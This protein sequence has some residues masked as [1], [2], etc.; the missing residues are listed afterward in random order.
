MEKYIISP[1]ATIMEALRVIN[2][3]IIAV[4]IVCENGIVRGVLTDGDL[5]RAL[6]GGGGLDSLIEPFYSQRYFS[7]DEDASRAD[8]LDLMQAHNLQHIPIV[9]AHGK[10]RGI[11]T[12]HS[13]L[14]SRHK[15]NVAVIMAGGL[16]SRLGKLTSHTPKPMLKVAGKPILER[17]VLHL[18]GHGI[19][20]IYLSVNYLSEVIEDYFGDGSKWGCSI[21][22]LREEQPLGSGGS[23]SL[24]PPQ[25]KP[26]FLLNG[27][28]LL[29]GNLSE[30]L[31]FHER[32]SFY[33]T[34]GT[35][36]YSHEVPYGC[37]ETNEG[38]IVSLEEKPVIAKTVNAGVYVLSPEAV[39]SIP[40]DTHFPVTRVFEDALCA[41]RA[42]G[43]F[44]LDGDWI[45]VGL[46]S[47]L[48]AARGR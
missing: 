29:E 20:N 45:D 5:R 35:H 18:L 14:G 4:A 19:R 46:P 32:G 47:Q 26:V 24:L 17:L 3:S 8:V 28:L 39:A 37:V 27:D 30:M 15:P 40:P 22:Y 2:E 25:D 33:A 6:I 44:P 7:V 38:T 23:L 12:M 42:C 11:H 36:F 41:N 9:D 48:D 13:I 31:R 43:A 21:R 34:M 1:H 16:G 10:L